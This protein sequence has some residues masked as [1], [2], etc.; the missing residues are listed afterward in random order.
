MCNFAV[1]IKNRTSLDD[2]LD[3]F[4]VH[5]IGGFLGN[6]LTGIFAQK[7]IAMLDGSVISGGAID[8]NWSVLAPNLNCECI[9][10]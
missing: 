5:G 10:R 2:T 7:W 9:F 8:G 6:I 4:S 1:H 3:T